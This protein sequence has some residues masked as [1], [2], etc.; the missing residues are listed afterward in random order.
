MKG[1]PHSPAHRAK[2]GETLKKPR[3][4]PRFRAGKNHVSAKRYALRSPRNRIYEFVNMA[5]FVRNNPGLFH[6]DDVLLK[7]FR[8]RPQSMRRWCRAEI[9]LHGLFA[10]SCTSLSWKGWTRVSHLA[11]SRVSNRGK[12]IRTPEFRAK[13][14]A[15]LM[16]RK[17]RPETVAKCVALQLGRKR[18]HPRVAA[19]ATHWRSKTCKLRSPRNRIYRVVNLSHFVR[20]HPE[21][22]LPSDVLWKPRVGYPVKSLR[23]WCRALNGLCRLFG[24]NPMLSWKG[25]TKV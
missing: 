16:G 3:V 24:Q 12:W 17:L 4:H 21:L 15:S 8:G 7:P 19:G 10:L 23:R 9:G 14:S 5:D 1:Q 22:F 18:R 2:I 6:P 13:V 25:W 11:R 20:N